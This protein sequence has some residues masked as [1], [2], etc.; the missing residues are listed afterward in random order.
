MSP[1]DIGGNGFTPSGSSFNWADGGTGEGS[2]LPV[3]FAR[4]YAD[5]LSD[6]IVYA[7]R[8][9]VVTAVASG[10]GCAPPAPPTPGH[11]PPK[12]SAEPICAVLL[13]DFDGRGTADDLHSLPP[14]HVYP[15]TAVGILR[16]SWSN[17]GAWVGFKG[18]D[19]AL[20]QIGKGTT[21]THADQGSF[22]LD[23]AGARFAEDLGADSYYDR[24]YFSF[25]KFD[26]YA[27]S[28][29]GHNTLTFSGLGQDACMDSFPAQLPS[30]WYGGERAPIRADSTSCRAAISDFNETEGWGIVDL[31]QSYTLSGA[32]GVMRGIA[33]TRGSM[34]AEDGALILDEFDASGALCTRRILLPVSLLQVVGA[35]R[36]LTVDCCHQPRRT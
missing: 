7:A 24:G 23:M 31:A 6:G 29:A 10:G 13:A 5:S 32:K 30:T 17:Q 4:R 34:E 27:S 22:V 20:Q 1:T 33:L 35:K 14:S 16:S 26:W 9:T 2:W 11:K 36:V 8:Q 3:A 18:G 28:T 25:Q 21:H 12:P 15:H 19:N